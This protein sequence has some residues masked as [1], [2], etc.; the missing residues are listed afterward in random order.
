MEAKNN[1]I[2]K[3]EKPAT[4]PSVADNVLDVADAVVQ[5]IPPNI[6][7]VSE[8][9]FIETV[10]EVVDAV[11]DGALGVAGG[12]AE[13]AGEVAEA[14]VEIAGEVISNIDF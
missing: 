7:S 2:K 4:K 6:D 9:E 1:I 10:A 14:V 11:V 13:S 12:I 8:T 3:N 5:I